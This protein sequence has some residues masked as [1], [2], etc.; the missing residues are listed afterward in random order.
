MK[1]FILLLTFFLAS[2]SWGQSGTLTLTPYGIGELKIG[3]TKK[4]I[5][6]IIRQKAM[7]KPF[8]DEHSS[9]FDTAH[10]NYRN[11]SLELIFFVLS[12]SDF[13]NKKDE[14]PLNMIRTTS[15]RIKTKEGIGIGTEKTKILSTYKN[16][17]V[18]KNDDAS[19]DIWV[20]DKEGNSMVFYIINNKVAS[21]A[22]TIDVEETPNP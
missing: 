14:L 10:C 1:T 20:T 11:A 5:E 21:M 9:G 6:S 22:V 3:S 19:C 18:I 12:K 4:D 17:K 7:L 2:R 13:D 8:M 15:P 16:N